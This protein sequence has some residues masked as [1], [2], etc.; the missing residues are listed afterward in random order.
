MQPYDGVCFVCVLE[1]LIGICNTTLL[2]GWLHAL[3]AST[4]VVC[5]TT[6]SIEIKTFFPQKML[7]RRHQTCMLHV[8]TQVCSRRQDSQLKNIKLFL[9]PVIER[10]SNVDWK[11]TRKG[12][13][14]KN[15]F[16]KIVLHVRTCARAHVRHTFHIMSRLAQNNKLLEIAKCNDLATTSTFS[17]TALLPTL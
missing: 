10:L 17:W 5:W 6:C 9:Y 7:N 12:L 1:T 2:K 15:F 14:V 4:F 8:L 3:H 11:G 16:K 13:L